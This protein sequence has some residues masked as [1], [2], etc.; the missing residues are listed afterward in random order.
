MGRNVPPKITA[1]DPTELEGIAQAVLEVDRL[2]W[3]D[4]KNARQIQFARKFVPGEEWPKL[5]PPDDED[6]CV[7]T[8]VLVQRWG[9][10][11]LVDGKVTLLIEDNP[12][13]EKTSLP[14]VK[15]E[16]TTKGKGVLNDFRAFMAEYLRQVRAERVGVRMAR[17]EGEERTAIQAASRTAQAARRATKAAARAET[18]ARKRGQHVIPN[19]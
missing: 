17:P 1:V 11:F 10:T 19:S 6:G 14:R 18:I 8:S 2:F 5:L 16:S 12:P 9:R 3:L 15:K 13:K 4:P 7:R